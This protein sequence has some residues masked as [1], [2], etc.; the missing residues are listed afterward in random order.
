VTTLDGPPLRSRGGH[1]L[2]TLRC[3]CSDLAEPTKTDGKY[4]TDSPSVWNVTD[5][6]ELV[7]FDED[8][9]YQDSPGFFATARVPAGRPGTDAGY[10]EPGAVEVDR[11]AGERCAEEADPAVREL[12][13]EPQS[14]VSVAASQPSAWLTARPARVDATE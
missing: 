9:Y 5:A 11:A 4:A 3:L 7:P 12:S 8:S 13:V 2:L 1:G 6:V 14:R 10:G